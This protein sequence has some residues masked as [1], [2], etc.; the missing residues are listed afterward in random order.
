MTVNQ[1]KIC[2]NCVM[3]T[4]DSQIVFDE[5]GVC[6]HCCDFKENIAPNWFPNEVGAR[7][8]HQM[9]DDIKKAG[10]K[11]EFDFGIPHPIKGSGSFGVN[12]LGSHRVPEVPALGG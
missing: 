4:T 2:S 8:L 1:I 3:D 11:K 10:K 6:D 12:P 7:L 9:V 5:N